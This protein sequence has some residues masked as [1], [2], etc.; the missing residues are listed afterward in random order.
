VFASVLSGR[1]SGTLLEENYAAKM[2][3]AAPALF[4]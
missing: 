3:I 1:I 4:T 2:F